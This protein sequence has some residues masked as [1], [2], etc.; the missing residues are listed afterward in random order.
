M[1]TYLEEQSPVYLDYNATTPVD[2]SVKKAIFSALD[3]WGN[4]SSACPLGTQ[5]KTAI[6]IARTSVGKLLNVAANDVIFTSGGTEANNWVL[7][8]AVKVHKSEGR[9]GKPHIVTTTIEHPAI[10]EP[11]KELVK[12]NICDVTFVPVDQASG[13]VD[14]G[15][16]VRSLTKDTCLVTVMLANNE[17][18]VIQPIAEIC[19]A[20]RRY[21]KEEQLK[22]RILTHTD[23]AQAVGKIPVDAQQLKVDYLTIV[24]HKFYGPRI[25]A[26]IARG[27]GT[28]P[29]FPFLFGG[30]QERNLRAGT[31][32]VPMIVGLGAAAECISAHGQSHMNHLRTLRDYFEA[33]IGEKLGDAVVVNFQSSNRLPNTSSVAFRKIDTTACDLLAKCKTF[34]AST[35]A[36]CHSNAPKTS[37]VLLASGV[38]EDLASKTVRFSIGRETTK[39]DID[40]VVS[41]LKAM[42]FLSKYGSS[43][44]NSIGIGKSIG[45]F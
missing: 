25:G 27:I 20:V 6:D 11:L 45:G 9:E 12:D 18:G 4:P 30:G 23:A 35:G 19:D 34:Y 8:L 39:E 40:R 44:L 43:L 29:M 1:A 41:E 10:I 32:N 3:L 33:E 24:G 7:H 26:L 16:I 17:T 22:H 21:A 5:A 2:E 42:T 28:V 37:A 15:A 31:E 13:K 36:A 14:P 38:S